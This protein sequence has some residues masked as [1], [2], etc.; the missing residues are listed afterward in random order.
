MLIRFSHIH[1]YECALAFLTK[2]FPRGQ[3]QCKAGKKEA[4]LFLFLKKK[5]IHTKKKKLLS[6]A[7]C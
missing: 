5:I 4:Y 3:G 2:H 1:L 7:S 6:A